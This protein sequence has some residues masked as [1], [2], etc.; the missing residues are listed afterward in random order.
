MSSA[1]AATNLAFFTTTAGDTS[2]TER[3]R[4]DS[5]GTLLVGTNS[6]SNTVA[7]A[8]FEGNP[9]SNGGFV[10]LAGFVNNV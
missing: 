3:L 10:G 8:I 2:P 9:T 1:S 6:T 5:G 4:I 7:S